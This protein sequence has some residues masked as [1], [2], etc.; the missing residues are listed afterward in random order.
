MEPYA[1]STILL[2][3]ER[4]TNKRTIKKDQTYFQHISFLVFCLKVKCNNCF[5]RFN[6][7]YVNHMYLLFL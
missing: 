6:I 7:G 3:E 4:R 1:T 2:A 5:Y